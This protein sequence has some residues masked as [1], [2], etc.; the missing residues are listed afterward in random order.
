MT[1]NADT[2]TRH[3][4][5]V[6]RVKHVRRVQSGGSAECGSPPYDM[7]PSYDAVAPLHSALADVGMQPWTDLHRVEDTYSYIGYHVPTPPCS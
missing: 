3:M 5:P 6:K 2:A 4:R 7:S 1:G